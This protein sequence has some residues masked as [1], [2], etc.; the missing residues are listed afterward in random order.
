[1]AD[2]RTEP[3]V[4]SFAPPGIDRYRL[5]DEILLDVGDDPK[6][7]LPRLLEKA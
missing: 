5:L 3:A 4:R 7:W 6:A 1:M 2:L